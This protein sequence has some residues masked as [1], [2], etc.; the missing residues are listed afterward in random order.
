MK[1]CEW[2]SD[3]SV[4]INELDAHH[5]RLFDIL[6]NLFTLMRE[7]ADDKSI[8]RILDELIDY[9]HYHFDEEEKIMA[10]MGY[11]ELEPHKRLHRELIQTLKGFQASTQNGMAIF[12]AT[13]VAHIGMDWLKNHILT[14]DHKYCE[15][16]KKQ[17]LQF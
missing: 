11:P 9:T 8:I 5:K 3:Y 13:K 4:G 14:V 16:M 10:K 1:V 6:D 17:G 7:G 2:N 12:V 15:Y